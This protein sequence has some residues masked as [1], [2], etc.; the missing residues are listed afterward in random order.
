MDPRF[1][2]DFIK[3]A[4]PVAAAAVGVKFGAGAVAAAAATTVVA[5]P[6]VVPIALGAA[7][8]VGIAALIKKIAD[9]E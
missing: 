5:A 1:G 8:V 4:V 6:V 3:K 2:G 9:S 7:A